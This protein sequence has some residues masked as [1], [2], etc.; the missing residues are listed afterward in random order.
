[1]ESNNQKGVQKT[2]YLDK[3]A[4]AVMKKLMVDEKRSLSD[5]INNSLREFFGLNQH[6]N[7]SDA[8]RQLGSSEQGSCK[9]ST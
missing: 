3:D 7:T 4:L 9:T 5:V 6:S 8:K 2:I 1:M